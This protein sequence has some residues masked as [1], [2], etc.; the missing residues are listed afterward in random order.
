MRT[1]LPF[2]SVLF[3][4]A[5][6]HNVSGEE[7]APSANPDI[8]ASPTKEQI[9]A[10]IEQLGDEEYEIR[11]AS[12]KALRN[13]GGSIASMLDSA[14]RTTDDAEMGARLD[15][16][17]R[18]HRW[19]QRFEEARADLRSTDFQLVRSGL[20]KLLDLAVNEP[21]LWKSTRRTLKQSGE[22]PLDVQ[23]INSLEVSLSIRYIQS[24]RSS[25][26]NYEVVKMLVGA[27]LR[28]PPNLMEERIEE[29]KT[30]MRYL[31][32]RMV[33]ASKKLFDA[34]KGIQSEFQPMDWFSSQVPPGII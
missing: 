10:W 12:E 5:A 3:I 25:L 18:G 16:L 15:R 13:A 31:F 20:Q 29:Y 7:S 2:L 6:T 9:A 33:A 1:A 32:A 17:L 34:R 26:I 19:M 24:I 23:I 21:D 11:E 22:D 14:Q 27:G 30:E 8:G 28:E 4:F